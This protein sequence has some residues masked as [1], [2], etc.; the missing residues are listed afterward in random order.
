MIFIKVESSCIGEK[1]GSISISTGKRYGMLSG[2][3]AVTLWSLEK[4]EF[5]LSSEFIIN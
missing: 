1:T 4:N 3:K 2:S 5:V